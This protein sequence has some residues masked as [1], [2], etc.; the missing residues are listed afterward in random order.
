[1]AVFCT[2]LITNAKPLY[3]DYA[4]YNKCTLAAGH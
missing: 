3:R 4:H 1:M 2:L